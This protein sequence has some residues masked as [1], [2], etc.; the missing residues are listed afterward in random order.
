[1]FS[2][3]WRT[4]S[5]PKG[6]IITCSSSSLPGLLEASTIFIFATRLRRFQ[7]LVLHAHQVGNAF[8]RQAQQQVHFLP[9]EGGAFGG[10]LHFHIVA[11][12]GHHHVHVGVASRV[13]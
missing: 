6:A 7:S 9:G 3:P 8:F 13:L 2:S 1:M 5:T 12:A 11:G 10:A 4:S